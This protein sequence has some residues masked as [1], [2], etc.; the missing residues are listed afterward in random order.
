MCEIDLAFENI[1][2]RVEICL[3]VLRLAELYATFRDDI[4]APEKLFSE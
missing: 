4:S 3:L 1:L 2:A